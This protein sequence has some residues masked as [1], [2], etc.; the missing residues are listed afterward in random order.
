MVI[1]PICITLWLIYYCFTML[2][3]IA[4][5]YA[6]IYPYYKNRLIIARYS[7]I[8]DNATITNI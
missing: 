8:D 1:E 4:M 6:F 7:S 3:Y 2:F 5:V